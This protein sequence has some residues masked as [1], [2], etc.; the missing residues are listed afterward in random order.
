[1][2]K[3]CSERKCIGRLPSDLIFYWFLSSTCPVICLYEKKLMPWSV[4]SFS[5][6]YTRVKCQVQQYT[7]RCGIGSSKMTLDYTSQNQKTLSTPLGFELQVVTPLEDFD[8][9]ILD[10][11]T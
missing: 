11:S 10:T 8:F 5:D 7:L 9:K 4:K 6:T 3:K 1:M 2:W